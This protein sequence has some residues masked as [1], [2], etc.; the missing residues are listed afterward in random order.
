MESK[1]KTRE[2]HEALQEAFGEKDVLFGGRSRSTSQTQ[3]KAAVTSTTSTGGRAIVIA[4]YRRKDNSQADYDFER[5]HE[6]ELER[7]VWEAAAATSASP[8]DFKPFV[9]PL[10]CRIY[11][12][13][14]LQNNNPAR[15]AN[16]ERKLIY[17]EAADADLDIFLSL[18]TGQHGFPSCQSFGRRRQIGARCSQTCRL[19]CPTSQKELHT[20]S[21]LALSCTTASTTFLMLRWLGR[22]SAETS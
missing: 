1:Y 21:S 9:N 3:S 17:S 16:R 19:L 12:D 13:G 2:F 14:A 6:P 20:S 11:L 10:T 18:G 4:N 7:R 5:P 22:S 8:T 15:I